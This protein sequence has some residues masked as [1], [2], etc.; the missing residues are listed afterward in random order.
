MLTD[1]MNQYY[2]P[3]AMR[4]EKM[5]KSDFAM[6]KRLSKWKKHIMRTWDD[7][8]L[9]DIKMSHETPAQGVIRLGKSYTI[10]ITLDLLDLNPEEVGVEFVAVEQV[11][12]DHELKIAKVD[13]FEF[14]ATENGHT[15]FRG[16][17]SP[18]RT[19]A[20]D[21]GYR[22]FPKNEE[23]SHRQDFPLIKWL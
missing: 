13:A 23:L 21:Y 12:A 22:V 16:K 19:G 6:A 7:I 11:E 10:D 3:Q 9:V 20:F 5:R 15:V 18:D 14:Y 1:Y 8:E 17:I 4:F 2:I